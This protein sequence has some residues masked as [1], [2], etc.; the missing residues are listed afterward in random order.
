[1]I[2]QAG[3]SAEPHGNAAVTS[4]KPD[5]PARGAPANA[6][7]SSKVVMVRTGGLPGID[8]GMSGRGAR[9]PPTTVVTAAE[10]DL[11]PA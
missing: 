11:A 1:L 5:A 3:R 7:S 4:R 2:K 6:S 8:Q 10:A 9:P